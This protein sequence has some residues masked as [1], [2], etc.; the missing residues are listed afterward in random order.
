ME[1]FDVLNNKREKLNYTKVRGQKLE[2][3]EYN[4]GVEIYITCN[5]KLLVTERSINKSHPLEWEVPGGCGLANESSIDTLKRE[6]KEEIGYDLNIENTMYIGTYLYKKNYVDI[7]T[8][9]DDNLDILKL[10]KQNEE[11][12]NIKL[13]TFEEFKK[14]KRVIS[15][16]SRFN[17][18]KELINLEWK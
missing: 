15:V 16:D 6:I 13:V 1:Y 8:L 12:N 17:K 14:L 5:N 7:Y 9:N 10:K 18:F 3:Y 11:I 4:F 2:D